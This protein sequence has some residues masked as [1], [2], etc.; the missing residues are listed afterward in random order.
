MGSDLRPVRRLA[1]RLGFNPRSPHGERRPV[2]WYP[3]SRQSFQSTLP[4]WGA[5]ARAALAPG[6]FK[7]FQSTLPAWGATGRWV[8]L[9]HLGDS[10]N[11][12]SPHGE[13]PVIYPLNSVH[14]CFNPRSPHGE[15]RLAVT[16]QSGCLC[17]NP[18]SPHGERPYG[19]SDAGLCYRFQSTLPAW[20]ATVRSG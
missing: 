7:E 11:P 19:Q 12:R 6:T 18:R 5:T 15:R 10:F 2:R 4:A 20:G 17:F 9:N 16:P 1:T 14:K 13:R 8:E 3:Q